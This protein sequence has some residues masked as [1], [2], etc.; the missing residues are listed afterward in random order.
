MQC[1][2]ED[3]KS[4]HR[5]CIFKEI[6]LW[7]GQLLYIAKGDCYARCI[8]HLSL[9]MLYG[10]TTHA[11]VP[12]ALSCVAGETRLPDIDINW[13]DEERLDIK[14]IQHDALP[15]AWNSVQVCATGMLD[16]AELPFF[17]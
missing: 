16:L 9:N 6:I 1:L 10:P 13:L 15:T 5:V 8:A 4:E 3:G 7:E 12:V 11:L 17:S 14:V 2:H